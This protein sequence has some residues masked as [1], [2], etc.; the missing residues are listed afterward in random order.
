MKY[1][2]PEIVE[3]GDAADLTLGCSCSGCDCGGG[4][5]STGSDE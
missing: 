5:K 3:L 4:K 2:A 1:E